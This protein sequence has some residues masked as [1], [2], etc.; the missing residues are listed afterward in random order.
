M[1]GLLHQAVN[2]SKNQRRF[3]L[4][5]SQPSTS[6]QCARDFLQTFCR[7][8]IRPRQQSPTWSWLDSTSMSPASRNLGF[9][10]AALRESQPHLLLAGPVPCFAETAGCRFCREE[11]AVRHRR[12]THR[13]NI[14][15]AHPVHEELAR[16]C[17]HHL[18]LR[19]Y[20]NLHS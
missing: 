19:S 18:S 9:P 12:N 11:L 2:S 5:V 15:I 13:K 1:S 7:S 8:K 16:L 10:T 17:Q 4:F 20:T 14:K 3:H 6:V